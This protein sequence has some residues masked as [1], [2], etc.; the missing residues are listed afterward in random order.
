MRGRPNASKS[1]S[2]GFGAGV[3]IAD[4]RH[5]KEAQITCAR[6]SNGREEGTTWQ[7]GSLFT[8][9]FAN[10]HIQQSFRLG[11]FLPRMPVPPLHDMATLQRA[12]LQHTHDGS[13]PG[14]RIALPA[15]QLA[16]AKLNNTMMVC[17]RSPTAAS[18]EACCSMCL[19]AVTHINCCVH[20]CAYAG[21]N[22]MLRILPGHAPST[23]RNWLP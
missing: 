7:D 10:I 5:P 9:I 8:G 19:P 2:A 13:Q 12:A 4:F 6:G 14:F 11:S 18:P 15:V 16:Q 17:P 3:R 21:Q 22:A 1:A 20:A 23:R